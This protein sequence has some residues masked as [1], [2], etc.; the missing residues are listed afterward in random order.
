[1]LLRALAPVGLKC[2]FRHRKS[3]LLIASDGLRQTVSIN[4]ARRMQQTGLSRGKLLR[5]MLIL[6]ISR[7]WMVSRPARR[8]YLVCALLALALSGTLMGTRAAQSVIGSRTLPPATAIVLRL[9]LIPEVIG[10]ALL[11]VAMLYFWFN[12]DQ[13]SW[14]KRALWFPF[15]FFFIPFALALYYFFVYRKWTRSDG[16]TSTV[17]AASHS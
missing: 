9:A 4:D 13:S 12:F 2:T 1:V 17:S 7:T 11:W 14:L 5:P 3:L 10:S 8:V 6:P 15:L 16:Q